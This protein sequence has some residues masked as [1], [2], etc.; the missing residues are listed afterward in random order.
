M[1]D[2]KPN[3][4]KPKLVLLK[5]DKLTLEK[6]VEFYRQLTGREMDADELEETRRE[7]EAK[8]GEG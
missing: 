7:L 1:S 3:M 2:T 4:T 6:V 5:A 8:H